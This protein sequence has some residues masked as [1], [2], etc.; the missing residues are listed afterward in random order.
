MYWIKGIAANGPVVMC[1]GVG[2]GEAFYSPAIRFQSFSEP[3]PLG[4]EPHK[5]CSVFSV[6]LRWDR[7]TRL[8]R[9]WIFPSP[10]FD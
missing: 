1:G 10:Y 6:P 8:G 3:M 2:G 4:C 7:I 9:S 5:C